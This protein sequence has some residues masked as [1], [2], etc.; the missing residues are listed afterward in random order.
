MVRGEGLALTAEHSWRRSA[1]P[2]HLQSAAA[3]PPSPPTP[4]TPLAASPRAGK[5]L[6]V[7]SQTLRSHNYSS[8]HLGSRLDRTS[9][10]S[11][12]AETDGR[13]AMDRLSN[14]MK[15]TVG[16]VIDEFCI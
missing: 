5:Q 11:R 15:A 16:E 8:T 14:R 7:R 12:K 4:R 1:H 2:N 3:A 13:E 10:S 6:A 9:I